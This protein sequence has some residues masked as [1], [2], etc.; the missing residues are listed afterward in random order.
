MRNFKFVP[1]SWCLQI[2]IVQT[3]IYLKQKIRRCNAG[4]KKIIFTITKLKFNKQRKKGCI[5]DMF[6]FTG[7]CCQLK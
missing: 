3:I 2:L 6:S 1:I 7:K 5:C 4:L